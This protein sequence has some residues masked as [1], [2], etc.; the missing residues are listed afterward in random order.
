[1]QIIRLGS[2][3]SLTRTYLRLE[4]KIHG[5]D[6]ANSSPEKIE[7]DRL[8]HVKNGKRDEHGQGYHFLQDFELPEGQTGKADPVG[9][10]LDHVFKKS[11]HPAHHGRDI[12]FSVQQIPEMSVPCKRHEYIGKDKQNSGFYDNWHTTQLHGL[13]EKKG[14]IKIIDGK[15]AP[16]PGN[17]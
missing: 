6:K 9:R 1:M 8:A 5:A 12:P 10:Y 16:C 4:D 13:C 7:F 17:D 14:E 2:Y 11:D 3:P 15:T